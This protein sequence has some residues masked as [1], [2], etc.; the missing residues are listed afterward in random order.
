MWEYYN[1][2]WERTLI[3]HRSPYKTVTDQSNTYLTNTCKVQSNFIKWYFWAII[4]IIALFVSQ[5]VLTK[6]PLNHESETKSL[7]THEPL[8]RVK[9]GEGDGRHS[10]AETLCAR[11]NRRN[12][13]TARI[14]TDGWHKSSN[15]NDGVREL[16]RTICLESQSFDLS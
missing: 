15:F 12:T 9:P 11:N 6:L 3:H 5:H 14:S 16:A 8:E 10:L 13:V 4:S 2:C 7:S 1:K